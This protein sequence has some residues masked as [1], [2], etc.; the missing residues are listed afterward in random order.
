LS[1]DG[2]WLA[3]PLVDGVTTNLWRLPATGGGSMTPLTD[4]GDRRTFIDRS[5]CWSPDSQGLFAAVAE[6]EMDIVLLDGLI[7]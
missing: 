1:P 3:T 6:E 7:G 2:R 5:I 4:F